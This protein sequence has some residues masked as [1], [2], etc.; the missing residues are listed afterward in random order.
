MSAETIPTFQKNSLVLYKSNPAIVLSVGPKI[1]IELPGK[2]TLLVRDKDIVLLH[3]GPV[4]KLSDLDIAIAGEIDEACA[5]LSGETTTLDMLAELIYGSFTPASAWAVCKLLQDGL[6]VSGTPDKIAVRTKEECEKV[7]QD[8]NSKT[9]EKDAWHAFIERLRHGKIVEE[10]KVRLLPLQDVALGKTPTSKI[11]KE[12]SL[13]ETPLQAHALLLRLAVWDHM[14][15]PSI[16]RLGFTLGV[17]YPP[18]EEIPEENRV[19]LTHLQAFAIDDEGN[20]DPDDA[21]SID[22]D[23]LWVHIADVASI[24]TP[25]S[26]VDIHAR[27]HATT[28][29]LPEKTVTMLPPGATGMLGLGLQEISP[30]LSFGITL[31]EDGSIDKIEIAISKVKV[32]RLTYSQAQDSLQTSPLSTIFN[33]TQKYRQFRKSQ[34]AIFLSFPEVK[35]QVR[36]GKVHIKPLPPMDTKEMVTDAMLMAGEAAARFAIENKL[37]FPFTAQPTPETIES[38]SDYAGMFA[39]RRKLK[40]SEVKCSPDQHAGLGIKAYTR[41]TS[42]LR[43]YLDLIAHQQIRAFLS[44]KQPLDE[45]QILNRIGASAAIFGGAQ[46]LE[47]LSNLHWTLVYLKQNPGWQ[48]KGIIVEKRER[49]S[50]LLIPEI[51]L[52]KRISSQHEL[53]LNQE[54]SVNVQSIDL[55]GLTAHFTCV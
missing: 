37:P 50:I 51:A 22:G 47:S 21:I 23:K 19:D 45:Q 29:Y 38:P 46:N 2:K 17:N 30:A 11:L 18:L 26:T 32:T 24:V 12:L 36:D 6:Y 43:R 15:N 25:D 55:P 33:L 41:A 20:Q 53:S 52:E 48:G 54:I 49:Y 34:N 35:I 44:N 27:G 39:Y 9:A 40:P 3:C 14:V 16:Q 31:Q 4:L 5:M 28:L 1:E 10:D 7:V 42:P 8:R 13:Q